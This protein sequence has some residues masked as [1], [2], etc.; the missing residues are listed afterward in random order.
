VRGIIALS[1]LLALLS[2]CGGSQAKPGIALRWSNEGVSDIYTLDPAQGPDYNTLMAMQFIYGGLVRFGPNFEILPD[3]A[4]HWDLSADGRV[5]EFYLQPNLRFGDGT[6]VTSADVVYS[7]NRALAPRFYRTSSAAYMLGNIVGAQDVLTG[8]RRTALGLQ[9][10]GPHAVMIRLAQ[11][12]GSFLAK[13][14]N[15]A[16]FIVPRRLIAANPST[17]Q[18]HAVGTGPFRV[19]RWIHNSELQLVPNRYYYAG[20]IAVSSVEMPFIPEPLTAY[21]RYRSGL[22]DVMGS[23]H[24]PAE[25]L[26]D[27][28]TDRSFYQSSDLE[29]VYL[30]LNERRAPFNRELVR[31]A[32]AHAVN[33]D[34]LVSDVYGGFARSTQAMMP[35]GL[36]G[37]N[38]RVHGPDYNPSLARRLLAKAGFPGGRGL[39]EVDV[40]VDQDAQSLHLVHALANQW[41]RALG[42][43]VR[44][45]P[46]THSGYIS[47]LS[48]NRF[49]IAVI[50]WSAD[51]PDPQNFLSQQLE[52]GSPNNN[53]G[54]SDPTFDALVGRADAMAATDPDR[55]ALYQRAEEIALSSGAAIPLVNPAAGILIRGSVH[56][57]TVSGGRVLARDW[58]K[59]RVSAGDA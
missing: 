43:H 16:G 2:A 23:V 31:L 47:L 46:Q 6:R 51:F 40:P 53:S 27:V 42:V 38:V 59:V 15:P 26:Y 7:L 39:P 44:V 24:F 55:Y 14:A 35:P 33:R 28:E 11:A 52:T 58:T 30:S 29:T 32:F 8:R 49:A 19:A 54:W 4:A 50:D 48:A 18:E 17:W 36:P 22:L 56:G 21:K 13:L 9:P 25:A 1:V 10:E 45:L 20:R 5:Y 12:D 37:Y 57:L 34:P 3:A 41:R